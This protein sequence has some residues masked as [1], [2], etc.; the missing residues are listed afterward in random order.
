M[1][2][3]YVEF[4]NIEKFQMIIHVYPMYIIAVISIHNLTEI[5]LVL[6]FVIL[7]TVWRQ[8]AVQF[9]TECLLGSY[10]RIEPAIQI[11]TKHK[12]VVVDD[13]FSYQL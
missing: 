9:N 11:Y 1:Y 5:S 6:L 3:L 12:E 7:T 10:Q 8:F 4:P 2:K 13:D